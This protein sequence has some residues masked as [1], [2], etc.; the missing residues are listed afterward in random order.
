MSSCATPTAPAK[1]PACVEQRRDRQ[2]DRHLHAVLALNLGDDSIDA[3]TCGD[4]LLDRLHIRAKMG[5]HE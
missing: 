5:R 3:F 2:R 1:A 4:A